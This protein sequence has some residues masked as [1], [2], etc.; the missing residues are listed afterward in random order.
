VIE[1]RV[2]SDSF[3]A[4]GMA[5]AHDAQG[6]LTAICNQDSAEGGHKRQ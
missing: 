1:V 2:D 3:N 5:G 6:N 4:H